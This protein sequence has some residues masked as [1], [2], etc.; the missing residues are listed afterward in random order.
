MP[1]L[2]IVN[3]SKFH[4]PSKA[5]NKEVREGG[6][7]KWIR[8]QCDW[9]DDKDVLALPERLRWIWPAMCAAA[10]RSTPPG[11]LDGE[12]V[13]LA[14][15]FRTRSRSLEM[16]VGEMTKRGRVAIEGG[17]RVAE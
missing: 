6:S 2:K 11:Y 3:F 14:R 5:V 1:R 10:G 8:L 7:L 16:V 17:G 15:V 13:D 9:Y 12:Y 4:P